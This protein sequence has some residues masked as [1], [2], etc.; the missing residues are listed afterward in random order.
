MYLEGLILYCSFLRLRQPRQNFSITSPNL[1]TASCKFRFRFRYHHVKQSPSG[2]G[3]YNDATLLL[4]KL[5]GNSLSKCKQ[6]P[7][8]NACEFNLV[9]CSSKPSSEQ[10]KYSNLGGSETQVTFHRSR[11]GV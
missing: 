3:N 9:Y 11:L 10:K 5:T 4:Y 8:V 6:W 2:D 1:L 7:T